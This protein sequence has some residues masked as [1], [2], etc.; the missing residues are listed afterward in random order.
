LARER[1]SAARAGRLAE[2]FARG[3]TPPLLTRADVRLV[4]RAF[5]ISPPPEPLRVPPPDLNHGAIS[6][7]ELHARLTDWLAD[8]PPSH[9]LVEVAAKM[10]SD[11][12]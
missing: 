4:A 3:E 7:A 6:R 11:A 9:T 5:E 12:A 8:L 1:S 10:G 2:A